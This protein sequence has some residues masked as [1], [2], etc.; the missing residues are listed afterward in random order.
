MKPS[1]RWSCG[2]GSVPQK[3]RSEGQPLSGLWPDREWAG[4]WK[5]LP[6]LPVFSNFSVSLTDWVHL[7]A[8]RQGNPTGSVLELNLPGHWA[9]YRKWKDDLG[10]D[11]ENNQNRKKRFTPRFKKPWATELSKP[12]KWIR[13]SFLNDGVGQIGA[14]IRTWRT[15]AGDYRILEIV[16]R[17]DE[18][19]G[20]IGS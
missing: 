2:C 12:E 16:A 17:K 7:K 6:L 19:N 1:E 9:G 5:E 10:R 4:G 18:L 13:W 11:M 14:E 3:L 8:R 20:H 15:Q